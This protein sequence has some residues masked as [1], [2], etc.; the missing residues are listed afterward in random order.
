MRVRRAIVHAIDIDFFIENFLYGLGKPAT[1]PIPS[2]SETFFP[3]GSKPPYPFDVKRA[4]AL[5]DEA[6]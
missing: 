2:T 6:G 1:G 3:G 5:L 4:E